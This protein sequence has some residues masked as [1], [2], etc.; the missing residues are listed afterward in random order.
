MNAP[1]WRVRVLTLLQLI[2]VSP[3]MVGGSICISADGGQSPELGFCACTVPFAGTADATIGTPGA[4]DCGPCRDESF[5][6]LKG[7]HASVP[8]APA[9]STPCMESCLVASGPRIA[10]GQAFWVGEPPGRRLPILRC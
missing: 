3:P 5:S 6:A 8:Q 2:L 7:A 9:P 10:D 4:A 1:S